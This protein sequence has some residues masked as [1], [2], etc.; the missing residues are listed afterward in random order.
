MNLSGFIDQFKEA[1]AKR[2]VES[3]P[4]LYRPSENGVK[5]P[6]LLR[7]PMGGQGDAIRG[8]AMSLFAGLTGLTTL[9]LGRNSLT[10]LPEDVFE[11]LSELTTLLAVLHTFSCRMHG[12]RRYRTAIVVPAPG[13][14]DQPDRPGKEPEEAS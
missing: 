5:L 14:V 9:S 12:L 8:A 7:T 11:G 1:I 13:P 10:T 3:Y 2:V 4:P 6:R